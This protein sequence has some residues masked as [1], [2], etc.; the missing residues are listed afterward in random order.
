MTTETDETR[1]S[2][3]LHSRVRD[4]RPDPERIIQVATTA[5]VR[6]LRRNRIGGTLAAAAC[7]SAV[8]VGVP[9]VADRAEPAQEDT[10]Y[11]DSPGTGA[12]AEPT[13]AEQAAEVEELMQRV[14]VRSPYTIKPDKR[15]VTMTA[16]TVSIDQRRQISAG[17]PA[18]WSVSYLE[19]GTPEGGQVPVELVLDGWSCDEFPVDDKSWCTG[20]D[21][22]GVSVNWR[23]AGERDSFLG[24]SGEHTATLPMLGGDGIVLTEGEMITV[25]G[26]AQGDWFVTLHPAV[27][28][29]IDLAALA[30]ALAWK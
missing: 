11:A 17:L 18:G 10:S 26:P 30:A 22:E 21:G 29:D 1:L 20:P 8:A 23:A 24:K 16:D 9:W 5:N 27:G 2:E 3:A 28:A 25:V 14:G 15:V 4:A 19:S 12:P 6:R 13:R 7:V